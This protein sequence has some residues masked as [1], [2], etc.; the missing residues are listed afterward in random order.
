MSNKDPQGPTSAAF[1]GRC[2]QA[3]V[4]T[5]AALILA[6]NLSSAIRGEPERREV[7]Q[8]PAIREAAALEQELL[9]IEA[10]MHQSLSWTLHQTELAR[11]HTQV[12]A[13]ACM[14]AEDH[15]KDTLRLAQKAMRRTL[16]QAARANAT[17]A[18]SKSDGSATS[19]PAQ[20]GT[21][22]GHR[23]G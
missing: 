5:M 13:I 6:F 14:S 7:Q 23:S 12:S 20:A 4:V 17:D 16:R 1:A 22:R 10:R 8:T 19:E 11:R 3:L 15:A 9:N 18:E 2:A 21:R